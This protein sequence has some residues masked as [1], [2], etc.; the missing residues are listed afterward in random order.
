MPALHSHPPRM[1]ESCPKAKAE[2]LINR[3]FPPPSTVDLFD[4]KTPPNYLPS[5]HTGKITVHEIRSTILGSISKKVPGE[6]GIPNL[7]LKILIDSLL[8][9]LYQ[10][11]N[12]C[13]DT[14]FCPTHFRSSITVVLRKPGKP[15]YT[16][17]KAYRPIALLNTLGKA[18]EFSLAKRIT[19]LT[20]TYE[21]LPHNHLGARRA[22][23]TEHALHYI[24]SRTHLQFMEQ[25]KN[26]FS[27]TTR[28]YRRF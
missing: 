24:Y 17:A 1:P 27:I 18:L 2:I 13:L 12:K 3:F 6:D 16:T 4:I 23:S 10:I 25:E 9:H 15:N 20:E 28:L 19:Y 21:L 5:Y 8:P 7:V 26:C 11:F 22:V 14:G